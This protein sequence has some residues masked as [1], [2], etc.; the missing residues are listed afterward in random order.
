MLFFLVILSFYVCE[1]INQNTTFSCT[2]TVIGTSCVCELL[3]QRIDYDKMRIVCSNKFT[4]EG[5]FIDGFLYGN[6]KLTYFDGYKFQ[7][8]GNF[9]R[10]ELFGKGK[11]NNSIGWLQEGNFVD[12]KLSGY[13]EIRGCCGGATRKGFFIDGKLNGHGNITNY[14]GKLVQDGEYI[15][16]KLH[17]YGRSIWPGSSVEEG[18]FKDGRLFQGTITKSN[19]VVYTFENGNL[20]E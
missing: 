13:G 19:G 7:E 17:G 15:N 6:G 8:E 12:G 1:I 5:T 4:A 10:G 14:D 18:F 9:I 16:G 20:I 11:K 2:S 3:E